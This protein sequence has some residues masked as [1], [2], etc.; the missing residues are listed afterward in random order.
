VCSNASKGSWWGPEKE[1]LKGSGCWAECAGSVVQAGGPRGRG[2]GCS[3]LS[4]PLG[5]C[6]RPPHAQRGGVFC[7]SSF[8]I[9]VSKAPSE[10]SGN[11]E[12]RAGRDAPGPHGTHPP[13][14]S[15]CGLVYFCTV[16]LVTVQ[17]RTLLRKDPPAASRDP[18]PWPHNQK[19]FPPK[20][21]P[22]PPNPKA[23]C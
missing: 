11:Q 21:K 6:T 20:K 5:A 14:H 23:E 22:F 19:P 17:G 16:S 9:M 8:A 4:G 15:A 12:L 3:L 18:N 13:S 10:T 2:S 1:R 7:D